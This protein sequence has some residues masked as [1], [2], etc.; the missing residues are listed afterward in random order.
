MREVVSALQV[1]DQDS[2]AG[3]VDS[4]QFG[5]AFDDDAVGQA[6]DED[7]VAV[8]ASSVCGDHEWALILSALLK[9]LLTRLVVY[10]WRVTATT[11]C[12]S[13]TCTMCGECDAINLLV[14]GGEEHA[15]SGALARRV[16]IYLGLV[17][18]Y[19]SCPAMG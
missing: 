18:S 8:S 3:G 10:C 16:Q 4:L 15:G 13:K 19:H 17:D 11:C 6:L 2:Q 1:E 12:C 9:R 5:F 7:D 14:G